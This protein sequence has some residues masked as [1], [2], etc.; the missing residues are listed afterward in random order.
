MS[1]VPSCYCH[2]KERDLALVV[3]QEIAAEHH[4]VGSVIQRLAL[5][6]CNSCGL[7]LYRQDLACSQS[8]P[9]PPE[10]RVC[11]QKPCPPFYPWCLW[12]FKP[13]GSPSWQSLV[14]YLPHPVLFPD[15][16]HHPWQ[17]TGG[18]LAPLQIGPSVLSGFILLKLSCSLAFSG[19]LLLTGVD[20]GG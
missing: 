6:L 15:C 7:D 20:S 19:S 8:T 18:L 2:S 4:L 17:S 9:A 12:S 16:W 10:P 3:H 13:R 1:D 14:Y 5:H 11:A